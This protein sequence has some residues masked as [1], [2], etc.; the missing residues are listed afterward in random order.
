MR[1]IPKDLV[2]PEV[3]SEMC[4]PIRPVKSDGWSYFALRLEQWE[5]RDLGEHNATPRRGN[6]GLNVVI[7]W[8]VFTLWSVEA[9]GLDWKPSNFNAE[10]R[11]HYLLLLLDEH[12]EPQGR[13]HLSTSRHGMAVWMKSWENHVPEDLNMG[14]EATKENMIQRATNAR[15]IMSGDVTWATVGAFE[16]MVPFNIWFRGRAC[17][18][19]YRSLAPIRPS[20]L[21]RY[22]RTCIL[23]DYP[24][25]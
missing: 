13:Y 17:Q 20:L 21:H 9:D 5:L 14:F 24:T 19:T 4:L 1:F 16:D 8:W 2:L 22:L 25:M 7:D 18:E 15:G 10:W 6:E 12:V 23:A 11:Y 3:S